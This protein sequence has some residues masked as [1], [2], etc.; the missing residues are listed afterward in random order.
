MTSTDFSY[1][2]PNMGFSKWFSPKGEDEILSE[3]ITKFNMYMGEDPEYDLYW[4]TGVQVKS[5]SGK[6]HVFG[7]DTGMMNLEGWG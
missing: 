1:P 3:R 4:M 7:R 5:V 2:Q 6:T